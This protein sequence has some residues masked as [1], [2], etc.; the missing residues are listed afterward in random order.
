MPVAQTPGTIGMSALNTRINDI[1][2]AANTDIALANDP[3]RFANPDF[4][5]G[6]SG[7]ASLGYSGQTGNNK[8]QDFAAGA[9]LRFAQGAFIQ[10]IGFAVDYADAAGVKSR[11]DVFAVHDADYYLNDKVYVFALGRIE[12]NGLASTAG[13]IKTAAFLGFG[14]GYRNL[15]T[16]QVTWP[17]QIGDGQS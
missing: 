16:Q 10:T 5:P 4:R 15:N 2:T 13:D 7:S 3:A 9:R 14:P 12:T 17:V 11:Q 6:L 1:Q 8:S